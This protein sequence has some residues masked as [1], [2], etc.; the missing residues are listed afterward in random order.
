MIMEYVKVVTIKHSPYRFQNSEAAT[1]FLEISQNS[2]ETSELVSFLIKLQ[3]R[4]FSREFCEISK[5]TFFT[6]H[7]W[8]LLFRILIFTKPI[9]GYS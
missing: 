2:L 3:A 4:V 8:W 5:S 6:E 7:L 9:N 1:M